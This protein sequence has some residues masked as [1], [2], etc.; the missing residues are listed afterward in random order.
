MD[1]NSLTDNGSNNIIDNSSNDITDVEGEKI[2]QFNKE[3]YDLKDINKEYVSSRNFDGVK[4]FSY[5]LD[6]D[7]VT[8]KIKFYKEGNSYTYV[9]ELND[10]KIIENTFG[11]EFYIVDLNE[12]DSQVEIVLYD[13]GPSGD[14]HYN[15]YSKKNDELQEVYTHSGDILKCDKK[16][17]VLI[18]DSYA[19]DFSPNI[20]FDYMYIEN[21]KVENKFIDVEKIK[22]ID[23]SNSKW[24]FSEDYNNKYRVGIDIDLDPNKIS[25]INIEKLSDNITFRIL[26]I[27]KVDYDYKI[28]VELSD[29]RKGY[30]FFIYWA[31]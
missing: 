17:L 22:N 28:Y 18:D 16:G 11:P 19:G 8:D 24:Y 10:K 29:G 31:G 14:P 12:N 7:G 6:G 20:Y 27:E 25:E 26:K 15:I 2:V 30:V 21:G 1:D 5:D 23:I 9:V 4:N 3:F 13:S